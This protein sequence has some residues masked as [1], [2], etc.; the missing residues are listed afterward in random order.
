MEEIV[1]KVR[2]P[3]SLKPIYLARHLL[4][5]E[6]MFSDFAQKIYKRYEVS[7]SATPNQI[8]T[9]V[10][11]ISIDKFNLEMVHTKPSKPLVIT[12]FFKKEIIEINDLKTKYGSTMV[13]THRKAIK[14]RSWHEQKVEL[15]QM[16]EVISRIENGENLSVISCAQLFEEHPELL[17]KLRCE[18][19]SELF[20]I[21]FF[22]EELFVGGKNASSAFHCAAGA[23]FFIMVTGRKK[24]VLVDP[25]D[26]LAMY[27]M[28]G[29]NP[30]A[31]IIG[32]PV[33][34][35]KSNGDYLLYDKVSKYE[36]I[37]NPGDILFNPSWWWHEVTNLSV[38][39]GCPLRT[40]VGGLNNS[41]FN[42]LAATSPFG[43]R[44]MIRAYWNESQKGARRWKLPDS[45]ILNTFP[46]MNKKEKK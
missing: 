41:F 23:N 46:G 12:N 36:A 26:S 10:E 16:R 11:R 44:N 27:P 38:A 3:N 45:M 42:L 24:W 1:P 6:D 35:A 39:I 32:S 37:L 18:E 29:L 31:A 19:L 43:I 20:R 2:I 21:S 4:K 33:N 28:I 30:S 9:P 15:I 22:R 40:M 25:R 14:G 34:S 5:R 8:A 17:D 13:P 7:I